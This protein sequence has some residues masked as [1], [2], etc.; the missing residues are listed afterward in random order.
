MPAFLCRLCKG[1]LAAYQDTSIVAEGIL[2][3]NK[4]KT[5]GYKV[6][7]RSSLGNKNA[8]DLNIRFYNVKIILMIHTNTEDDWSISCRD[9]YSKLS[10]SG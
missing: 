5:E 3:H 8:Y 1:I 10:S 9:K 7:K 4:S 6:L 2:V